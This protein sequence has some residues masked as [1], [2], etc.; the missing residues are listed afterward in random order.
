MITGLTHA[1]STI[2]QTQ[3]DW[4]WS[5]IDVLSI[6]S[7]E[8]SEDSS[9]T[10]DP[11]GNIH[12]VW[13]DLTD[14]SGA[15][16]DRDI[17]YKKW[18]SSSHTWS[19]IEIVS[20]ESTSYSYSPAIVSDASGSLHVVYS[21][22]TNINGAGSD[23]DIF[24]KKLDFNTQSW[25]SPVVI[26]EGVG[27]SDRPS[28]SV[29]LNGIYIAWHDNVDYG[30]S[31]T[32]YDILYKKW[33]SSSQTW[34]TIEVV[35]TE[36]TLSSYNPKIV[37]D[38]SGNVHVTWFDYTDFDGIE[39]I[40]ADIFYKRWDHRS[41]AWSLT[42]LIS[43][44]NAEDSYYP[45]IAVDLNGNIH[46]VWYD[47]EDYDGAGTDSDIFYK[48]WQS[49]SNEWLSA[50]LVSSES[51]DSSY[52]PSITT[53]D[54]GNVHVVW[55]DY[56]NINGASSNANI[57]YKRLTTDEVTWGTS[58]QVITISD[59]S[60]QNP[61]ISIDT[62]QFIHVAWKDT[63]NYTNSGIE[64]DIFY[65]KLS[66]LPEEPVL[67]D[68]LPNPNNGIINLEWT[69][70]YGAT[71]YSIYR[72]T[73]PIYSLDGLTA[74]SDVTDT[75]FVDHLDNGGTFYYAITAN[76]PEGSV[77]SNT[78]FVI[79]EII[80]E[81]VTETE[82]STV[83]DINNYTSVI[84]EISEILNNTDSEGGFLDYPLSIPVLFG[85]ITLIIMIQRKRRTK[86]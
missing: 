21:D 30:G 70:A 56:S 42:E 68:I 57:F 75:H 62:S 78:V 24:Y 4:E 66:G 26:S 1:P 55:Y 11:L 12:V 58:T 28:I 10:S 44:D 53:D 49:K 69:E 15:G 38:A 63:T 65:T 61:V 47:N 81:T 39:G 84:T 3:D 6:D 22:F 41:A 80:T 43:T 86:I 83:I 40:D 36:S 33:D 25:S 2:A 60:S 46:I 37:N 64:Y 27:F 54:L 19:T 17:F 51:E 31:G 14:L 76:N 48:T 18:N 7:T 73:E 29:D 50:D 45:S 74:I 13:S 77:L 82:T 5:V 59:G 67:E 8:S 32:D 52:R 71:S 72:D 9:I 16:T 35:S 85:S 20:T 79:V 34:S 23:L